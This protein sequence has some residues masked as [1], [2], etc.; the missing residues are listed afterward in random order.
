MTRPALTSSD[1][2]NPFFVVG[3]ILLLIPQVALGLGLAMREGRD[4]ASIFGHVTAALAF[5]AIVWLLIYW[6]ARALGKA[7]SAAA[8]VHIAFAATVVGC[9]GQMGQVTQNANK[10]IQEA[11]SQQVTD[12]ERMGLTIGS[13]L[14]RHARFGFTLPDPGPDFRRDSAAQRRVDSAMAIQHT[15]RDMATWIL[16]SPNRAE[17]IILQVVKF[18]S[19]NEVAF[20]TFVTGMRGAITK[21]SRRTLLDSLTWRGPDGEYQLLTQSP[22][23]VYFQSRCLPNT[24][25]SIGLIVC[26]QTVSHDRTDLEFVR[27]GL[28]FANR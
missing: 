19:L 18:P 9:V 13:G 26:V 5:P 28:A 4:P 7:R 22:E 3:I 17:A 16:T 27:S 14:I 6:V 21:A 15:Q 10:R 20:R 23:G 11:A 25:G 2:A 1:R 12:S 24:R 8:K